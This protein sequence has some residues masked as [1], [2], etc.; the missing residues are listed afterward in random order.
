M[1]PANSR[2]ISAAS[3]K[4]YVYNKHRLCHRDPAE[5]RERNDVLVR[6]HVQTPTHAAEQGDQNG[7]HAT[8]DGHEG[9]KTERLDFDIGDFGQIVE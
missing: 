5:D 7:E 1:K 6:W 3:T 2:I 8:A 9:E 4:A